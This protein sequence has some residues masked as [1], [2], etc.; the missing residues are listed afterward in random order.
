[1]MREFVLVIMFLQPVGDPPSH[2]HQIGGFSTFESCTQAAQTIEQN[3][4]PGSLTTFC[5]ER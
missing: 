2:S 5:M 3:N 4:E 1:M